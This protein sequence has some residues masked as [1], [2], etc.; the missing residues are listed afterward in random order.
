MAGKELIET[1]ARSGSLSSRHLPICTAAHT[2]TLSSCG[3]PR[4][5]D[6]AVTMETS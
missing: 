4:P 2:L 5:Q 1:N 3:L 6:R